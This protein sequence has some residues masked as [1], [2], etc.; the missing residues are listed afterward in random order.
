MPFFCAKGI[1]QPAVAISSDL[2]G[3]PSGHEVNE[4]RRSEILYE[5][6]RAAQATWADDQVAEMRKYVGGA[7]WTD[8]QKAVI[9]S[10]R[11]Q[12]V[13]V[14]LVWQLMRQGVGQLTASRPAFK[15]LPAGQEDRAYAKVWSDLFDHMWRHSRGQRVLRRVVQDEYVDGRGVFVAFI[16]FDA[17]GGRGEVCFRDEDALAVFPD[18]K[19]QHPLWDDARHVIVR[20]LLTLSQI[21]RL[22]PG[23][24][25]ASNVG[26]L[27]QSHEYPYS[28]SNS[29]TRI[30]HPWD[31]PETYRREGQPYEVI[32]RYTKVK[33]R[34]YRLAQPIHGGTQGGGYEEL[35]ESQ[36]RARLQDPAYVITRASALSGEEVITDEGGVA[37]TAA[38]AQ[39]LGF[40]PTETAIFHVR[41]TAPGVDPLGGLIPGTPERVPGP[42]TGDPSEIPG[43]TTVIE[44]A[45]IETLI[46]AGLLPEPETFLKTQIEVVVSSGRVVLAGPFTL[47]TTHYPVVPFVSEDVRHPYPTS[48]IARVRDIQDMYNKLNSLL[49]AWMANNTNVKVF[50]PRGTDKK[51]LEEKWGM[52][53]SAVLEYDPAIA[54][55]LGATPQNGGI[56]PVYP[57]AVPSGFFTRLEMLKGLMEQILGVFAIQ[58]GDPANTPNTAFG[59]GIIQEQG[60]AR[61]RDRGEAL[62]DTLERLGTVMRDLAQHV[63]TGKKV[64]RRLLPGGRTRSTTVNERQVDRISGA[65]HLLNDIQSAEV[66]IVIVPGS[67]RPVSRH[68][69]LEQILQ[70][71]Q[72]GVAIDDQAI[73]ERLDL[74]DTE[75]I[76]ER[77]GQLQQAMQAIGQ[78]E[79]ENKK[80]KGDLQTAERE[81]KN[82]R[83]KAELHDFKAEVSRVENKFQETMKSEFDA[84]QVRLEAILRMA[85]QSVRQQSRQTAREEQ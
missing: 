18:P 33:K 82:A 15:A 12:A 8:A 66:D 79:E 29:T 30:I 34:Y 77:T 41:Q 51:K 25:T 1:M 46:L 26:G 36:Y 73:L 49:Q 83:E 54:G 50:V 16:D 28:G 84:F 52:A 63:Y 58:Q 40:A 11:Q 70:L 17:D 6:Y 65:V 72:Q 75:E 14:E 53:G 2:S 20:K 3:R 42:P 76:L 48:S 5:D 32:D 23:A 37:E 85:E 68:A 31:T 57:P 61:S 22:W 45:T 24:I 38:L 64:L 21:E 59:F 78:L 56:V 60:A 13:A 74:Q 67:T 55:V 47:P 69:E 81:A 43:T 71:R 19:S 10:R 35:N 44:P 27:K 39:S 4:A 80:L 62:E 7:H 9:E